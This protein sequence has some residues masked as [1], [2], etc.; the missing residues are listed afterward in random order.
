MKISVI[1]PH[2]NRQDLVSRCIQSVAIQSFRDFELII[3]DDGSFPPLDIDRC[4]G[5]DNAQVR[6]VRHKRNLGAA[7][8]RN[9]GAHIAVGDWLAFLDSDDEWS[10]VKLERQLAFAEQNA[11]SELPQ[12]FG[13]GFEL[14]DHFRG[15][16]FQ[17]FP[18]GATSAHE[19]S[20]GCWHCPGSTLLIRKNTFLEFGGFDKQLRRLED[21]DFFL[22]FGLA[23]GTLLIVPEILSRIHVSQA[24]DPRLVTSS[25]HYI[26][27]MYLSY[28]P[29]TKTLQ[30]R[31]ASFC[32]L[33]RA[34]AYSRNNRKCL[35][36]LS[37]IAS[38]FLFPRRSIQLIDR[39]ER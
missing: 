19:F 35:A 15:E 18:R 22:R 6:L 10:P 34:S 8:A 12:A 30:K 3:V 39:F 28:T 31:I 32:W 4:V 25:A 9:T 2:W 37:F 23:G 38:I 29:I 27:S 1:C 16:V 20:G 24:P 5:T 17:R 11:G 7:A 26:I 36:L 21:F 33:A 14:I 13:T